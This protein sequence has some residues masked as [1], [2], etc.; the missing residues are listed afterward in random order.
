MFSKTTSKVYFKINVP[1]DEMLVYKAPMPFGYTSPKKKDKKKKKKGDLSSDESDGRDF[2]MSKY[3][4]LK[5]CEAEIR[6]LEKKNNELKG[7]LRHAN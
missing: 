7:K 3:G 6:R 1:K 2:D 4:N 5:D